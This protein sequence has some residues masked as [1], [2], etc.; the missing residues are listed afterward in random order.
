MSRLREAV[1]RVLQR[2]P[3]RLREERPFGG[4]ELDAAIE[5]RVADA[6]QAL[7]GAGDVGGGGLIRFDG[8]AQIA[9]GHH[10]VAFELRDLGA[11]F[12]LMRSSDAA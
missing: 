6:A 11:L 9:R 4:E 8:L 7:A 10:A 2:G 1:D 12:V 3:L 5:E